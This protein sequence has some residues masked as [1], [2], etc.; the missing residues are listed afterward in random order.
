MSKLLRQDILKL[1]QL[2]RLKLSDSEVEEFAEEIGEI[3]QYVQQLQSVDLKGVQ[4]T[5]QVT[6]LKDVMRPDQVLDYG[7]SQ[8]ELLKNAPA[9][10]DGHFKV[11]RMLA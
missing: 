6:G 11:K 9:T 4:P 7:T 3:L 8:Q 1:A 2:S 5:Y 10:L